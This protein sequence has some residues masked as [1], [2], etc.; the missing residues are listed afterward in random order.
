MTDFNVTVF[1]A[2]P[3]YKFIFKNKEGLA[4]V[5]VPILAWRVITKPSVNGE[6][7]SSETEGLDALGN[8]GRSRY[9]G[10]VNPNGYMNFFDGREYFS[11]DEFEAEETGK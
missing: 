5:G 4:D 8:T 1:P 2:E 9:L 7:I 10:I 3:G 11:W 6:P